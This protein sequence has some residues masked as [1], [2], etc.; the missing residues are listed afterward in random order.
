MVDKI[1]GR[2]AGKGVTAVLFGQGVALVNRD[3]ARGRK[4]PGVVSGSCD[5]G[6]Q[7][8]DTASGF[9]VGDVLDLLRKGEV[10]IALEIRDGHQDVLNVVTIGA[11]EFASK[12]VEGLAELGGA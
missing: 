2:F 7:G 4:K 9:V 3:S 12:A 5:V 1:A 8:I 6:A 11:D 10:G